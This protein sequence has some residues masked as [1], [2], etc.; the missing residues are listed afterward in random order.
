MTLAWKKRSYS[1]PSLEANERA[2]D[3][4]KR[5]APEIN[6]TLFSGKM[7]TPFGEAVDGKTIDDI[8]CSYTF[9]EGNDELIPVSERNL[10]LY[11]WRK[12]FPK[13]FNDRQNYKVWP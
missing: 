13:R 7:R 5:L 11:L 2:Y 10:T 3:L 8:C 12:L 6:A 9:Y 1:A 4:V